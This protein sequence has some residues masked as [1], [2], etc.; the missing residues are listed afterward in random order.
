MPAIPNT[1]TSNEFSHCAFTGK[2]LRFATMIMS[3]G[4]EV[5]HIIMVLKH[6]NLVPLNKLIY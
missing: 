5:Y 2:V 4:Y 1:I 3:L 6:Q